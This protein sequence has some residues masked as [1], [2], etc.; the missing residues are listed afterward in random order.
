M[1]KAQAVGTVT[2]T[3]ATADSRAAEKKLLFLPGALVPGIE[4]GRSDDRGPFRCLYR[5]FVP[6]CAGTVTR[7]GSQDKELA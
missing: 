1:K 7:I 3:K 6:P 2:I 4:G 5:F